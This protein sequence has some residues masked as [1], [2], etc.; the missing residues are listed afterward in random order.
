MFKKNISSSRKMV[1][2]ELSDKAKSIIAKGN[3]RT[4]KEA[5]IAMGILKPVVSTDA[6]G[7]HTYNEN[8]P[9]NPEA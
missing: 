9:Y 1:I 3:S 5:Y 4:T 7:N 6:N 8:I 2:T